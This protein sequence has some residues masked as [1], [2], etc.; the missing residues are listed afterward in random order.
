MLGFILQILS[1]FFVSRKS[2]HSRVRF[3]VEY[4][5]VDGK[6]ASISIERMYTDDVLYLID[7]GGE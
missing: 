3:F 6:P 4:F 2:S 1:F 5:F 7:L